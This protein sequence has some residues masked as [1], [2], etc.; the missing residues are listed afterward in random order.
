MPTPSLPR[1][2]HRAN[3]TIPTAGAL[4]DI[5]NATDYPS[6]VFRVPMGI[7][8]LAF[9]PTYTRA[10]GFA[11]AA[12]MAVV[13]GN[14]TES[15]LSPL[16]SSILLTPAPSSNAALAYPPVFVA[17]MP[18]MYV[19]VQAWEVGDPAHPGKLQITMTGAESGAPVSEKLPRS[20]ATYRA[21][22]ALPASGAYTTA[23]ASDVGGATHAT[24]YLVV[25]ANPAA[26]GSGTLNW[27]IYAG[28]GAAFGEPYQGLSGSKDVGVDF[29]IL[30]QVPL[31][32]GETTVGI[33]LAESGDEAHPAS[34]LVY[35]TTR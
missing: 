9:W 15:A 30:V 8:S 1:S 24:F 32:G 26:G 27:V 6:G 17:V 2:T 18:G 5:A 11:G 20:P 31:L 12:A 7:N 3:T 10:A 4:T 29:T 19:W 28:N 16:F 35:L 14:G 34:V 22:A 33:S 25:T 23:T 21:N 13:F